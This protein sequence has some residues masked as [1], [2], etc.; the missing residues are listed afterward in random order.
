M[1]SFRCHRHRSD[2]P[3]A[4]TRTHRS[5]AIEASGQWQDRHASSRV[6]CSLAL[7][8]AARAAV[9]MNPLAGTLPQPDQLTNIPRL[10]TAYYEAKPDPTIAAQRVSFGTSG[11][12]GSSLAS[13]FNEWH[14]LAITQAI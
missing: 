8:S 13:G 7:E 10:I 3:R 6:R 1:G 2:H 5:S 4:G 12:R 11:H 14:V 9:T